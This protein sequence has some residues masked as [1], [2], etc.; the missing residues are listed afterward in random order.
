[1]GTG[2][3]D[4]ITTPWPAKAAKAFLDGPSPKIKDMFANIVVTTVKLTCTCEESVKHAGNYNFRYSYTKVI[5]SY[6][7]QTFWG[8]T[9]IN[10]L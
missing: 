4:T 3:R 2:P 8:K 5:H 10:V 6:N 9:L 1:M 7:L